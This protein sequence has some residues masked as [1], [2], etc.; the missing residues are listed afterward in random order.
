MIE[1]KSNGC[2]VAVDP[3][4]SSGAIAI[5]TWE[6]AAEIVVECYNMPEGAEAILEFFTIVKKTHS[7]AVVVCENVGTSRP[8]NSAQSSSTFAKHRGHLEMAFIALNFKPEWVQPQKWMKELLGSDYPKGP[9]LKALRKE[10]IYRMVKEQHPDVKVTK[11]QADALAI[12]TWRL[13]RKE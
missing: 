13:V 1:N 8:G 9:A 6:C 3:G 10:H 4:S 12:L 7:N 11:R 2:V 5:C